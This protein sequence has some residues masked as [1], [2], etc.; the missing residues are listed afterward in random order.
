MFTSGSTGE[1]KGA[2]ISHQ[3]II[4]FVNWSKNSFEI[5]D[6]DVFSQLN[7]LYFDNSVFDLYNSLLHGCTL[8]LT[9]GLDIRNPVHLLNRLKKNKCT[10][11]FSTPSFL[12]II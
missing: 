4:N 5:S 1:P 11:W 12:S 6:K 10:V 9:N 3:S 7:P 8:V 2:I